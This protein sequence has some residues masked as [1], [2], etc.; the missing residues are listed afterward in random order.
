MGQCY[1]HLVDRLKIVFLLSPSRGSLFFSLLFP[2]LYFSVYETEPYSVEVKVP[3]SFRVKC[4]S[5]ASD[6]TASVHH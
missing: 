4:N 6:R 3:S 2:E 5:L 1:Y